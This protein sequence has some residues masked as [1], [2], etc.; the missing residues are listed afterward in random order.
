MHLT[1][2]RHQFHVFGTFGTLYNEDKEPICNTLEEVYNFNKKGVSCIPEGMYA[3]E[4][5]IRSSNGK[6]AFRINGVPNRT[7]ILIHTGNTIED[8]EGCILPGQTWG[9]Y[10]GLPAV[11][12]SR[13][14]MQYLLD[15]YDDF[16]LE[17]QNP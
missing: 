9:R 7:A 5:I 6:P 13:N 4:K 11:L 1:L 14:A 15:N 16:H 2:K 8:V 3:V 12:D 17:I 10:K